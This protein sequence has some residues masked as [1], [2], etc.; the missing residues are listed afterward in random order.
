[1]LYVSVFYLLIKGS[2]ENIG[3]KRGCSKKLETF[4]FDALLLHCVWLWSAQ[5][6]LFLVSFL[7]SQQSFAS[8]FDLHVWQR[9]WMPL[10]K[11]RKNGFNHCRS[12]MKR[13]AWTFSACGGK[14]HHEMFV[15]ILMF[16]FWSIFPLAFCLWLK[17]SFLPTFIFL[18]FISSNSNPFMHVLMYVHVCAACLNLPET[19]FI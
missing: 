13:R 18:V 10:S 14:L 17:M 19:N 6:W 16:F 8:V 15:I 12:E 11:F 4:T 3:K 5:P 2:E 7:A 9:R 1:M